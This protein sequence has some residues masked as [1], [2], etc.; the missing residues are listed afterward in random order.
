MTPEAT[1]ATNTPPLR[2]DFDKAAAAARADF[3]EQTK[4]ITFIN[5]DAPDVE[6]QMQAFEDSLSDTA[7]RELSNRRDENPDFLTKSAMPTVW[8]T[9]DGKGMMLAYGSRTHLA[10]VEQ[11]AS[12][13]LDTAKH[14]KYTFEHELGHI[15]V[16]KADSP[17]NRAE[18]GADAFAILRGMQSNFLTPLD[19][20]KIADGRDMLG[21]LNADVTHITSMTLDA[22][23]INPKQTDFLKLTPKETAAIA[24]KHAETFSLTGDASAF[25][26][27]A[28][29][30]R[31]DAYT[32]DDM[33]RENADKLANVVLKG[34]RS[35]LAFYYAARILLTAK[36]RQ[37]DGTELP[38]SVDFK[39]EKWEKVFAAIEKKARGRDIGAAKA[40]EQNPDAP[41]VDEPKNALQ[42]LALRLKPLNV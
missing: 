33:R 12:A 27:M 25:T 20:K 5:L 2:F 13:G 17:T 41:H 40:V 10:D 28:V 16:P 4:N 15:V 19:A 24:A 14:L 21:W 36:A 7:K 8:F 39:T 35:G 30:L 32:L 3:P 18:H 31:R 6:A 9:T 22:I 34:E 42:K 1:A 38:H 26:S 11:I 23:I 37:E 29:A